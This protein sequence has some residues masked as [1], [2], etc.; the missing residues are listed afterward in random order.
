MPMALYISIYVPFPARKQKFPC[1]PNMRS[2]VCWSNGEE[3]IEWKGW[4]PWWI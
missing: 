4:W 3:K 1:I 2:L